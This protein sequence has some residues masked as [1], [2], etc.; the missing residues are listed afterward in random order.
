LTYYERLRELW[1]LSL[2]RRKLRRHLNVYKHWTAV[3]EIEPE[4]SQGLH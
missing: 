3:W 1:L 2:R 4:Y